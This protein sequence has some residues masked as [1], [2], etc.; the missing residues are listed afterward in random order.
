MS[1]RIKRKLSQSG[2]GLVIRIP[3]EIVRALQYTNK[4][5]VWIWIDEGRVIIEKAKEP[6]IHS[7]FGIKTNPS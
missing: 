3:A 6:A 7:I 1:L 5:E 4:N 2:K